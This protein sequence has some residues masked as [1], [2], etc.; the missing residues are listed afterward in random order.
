[1][2]GALSSDDLALLRGFHTIQNRRSAYLDFQRPHALKSP[3]SWR[4][5]FRMSEDDLLTALVFG[6]SRTSTAPRY[7]GFYQITFWPTWTEGGATNGT[8]E[9]DVLLDFKLGDPPT[10]VQ[11]IVEAKFGIYPTQYAD[12]WVRQWMA[13]R[14]ANGMAAASPMFT[15][16][17][18]RRRSQ[19]PT[20][21]S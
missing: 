4:T 8:V 11:L 19:A 13:H 1:M 21:L 3:I 14:A 18:I 17:S 16:C 10:S 6:H 12:Q 15:L 2:G 5:A 20:S 7:G 9:P